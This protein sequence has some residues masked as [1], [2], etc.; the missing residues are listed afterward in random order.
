MVE[1]RGLE[2]R[3]IVLAK[4]NRLP[5]TT[6]RAADKVH[7]TGV[8]HCPSGN[9]VESARSKVKMVEETGLEPVASGVP[10]QRS[11]QLSYT[12]M[13]LKWSPRPGSNRGPP[14]CHSGALPI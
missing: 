1:D 7:D 12:P 8:L 4:N 13:V 3:D 5:S 6:P 9:D 14:P 2:P 10:R 11:A